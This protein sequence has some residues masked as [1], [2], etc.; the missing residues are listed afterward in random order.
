MNWY[1]KKKCLGTVDSG[2]LTVDSGQHTA[3][4]AGHKLN[5]AFIWTR[6]LRQIEAFLQ[7]ICLAGTIIEAF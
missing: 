1:E 2:D 4:F 5:K 7:H 3:T 6:K